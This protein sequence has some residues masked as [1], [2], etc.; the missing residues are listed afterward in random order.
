MRYK[1]LAIRDRALDAY[2]QPFFAP[3][4]G[5]AIR[6]FSDE[7]NRASDQNQLF[8]HPEDFD[9]FSLGEFDDATGEFE[10]T[11][12]TQLAVGKDLATKA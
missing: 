5:A 6:S 10:A 2:G 11:R 12:P 7:I 1:I 9:L 8:K 3:S 4:H